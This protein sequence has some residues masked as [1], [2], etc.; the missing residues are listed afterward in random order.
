MAPLRTG[1][2][3]PNVVVTAITST[4][5]LASDAEDTWQLLLEGHSGIRL[6]DKPF[7]RECDGCR[8]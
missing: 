1:D 2:G 5:P 7:V 4:T 6:L 3:F 8:S